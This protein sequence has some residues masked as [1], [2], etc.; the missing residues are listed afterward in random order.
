MDVFDPRKN[1]SI[2]PE[3]ESGVRRMIADSEGRQYRAFRSLLEAKSSP[4]SIAVFE[5]DYGGQIYVVARVSVISC[6]EQ[7][8]VSLLAELDRLEW[9]DPDGTGLYFE[10]AEIGQ[11][12]PGGMGGGGVIEG[13]WV[14]PRLQQYSSKIEEVLTGRRSSLFAF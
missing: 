5:G 3:H 10:E 4:D 13:V 6:S 9:K 2:L 1:N 14:H 7:V 11:P 8:L 12:I